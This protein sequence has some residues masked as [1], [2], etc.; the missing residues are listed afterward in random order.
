[1][2]DNS[3]LAKTDFITAIDLTAHAVEAVLL[4]VFFLWL[5][6]SWKWSILAIAGTI[7]ID[8][9]HFIDYF[10]YYGRRFDILSFFRR[11]YSASGKCYLIFHSLEA[12]FVLWIFSMKFLWITPLATGM[13]VHLLTDQ[14]LSHQAKPFALF[15]LWRW[16]NGFSKSCVD[17]EE[18]QGGV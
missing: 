4:A 10:L 14:F 5:T 17:D 13:T 12:V 9:D 16:K 1:M 11:G 15:L 6:L 7:L 2:S 3:K 8:I 18:A